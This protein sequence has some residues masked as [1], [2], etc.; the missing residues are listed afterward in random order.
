MASRCSACRAGR[1]EP[2]VRPR[3]DDRA[4]VPGGVVEL[5]DHLDHAGRERAPRE[6]RRGPLPQLVVGRPEQEAE[7]VCGRLVGARG[8]QPV[9]LGCRLVL[10]GEPELPGDEPARPGQAGERLAFRLDRREL[11]PVTVFPGDVREL[12]VDGAEPPRP[13]ERFT[14]HARPRA[15]A[16]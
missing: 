7:V 11:L 2:Q 1:E 8:E 3:V 16:R 4:A 12:S 5:A 9:D 10:S 13:L 15:S 6:R 14:Q